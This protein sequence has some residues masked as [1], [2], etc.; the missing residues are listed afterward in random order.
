MAR[1]KKRMQ[2]VFQLRLEKNRKRPEREMTAAERYELRIRS[3][4]RISSRMDR[5]MD[6]FMVTV[7]KQMRKVK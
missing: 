3:S 6:G 2:S 1:R 7:S 5:M 4:A